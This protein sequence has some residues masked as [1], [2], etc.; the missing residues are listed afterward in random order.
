[1]FEKKE[2]DAEVSIIDIWLILTIYLLAI[3]KMI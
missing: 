1:M 3:K 2:I